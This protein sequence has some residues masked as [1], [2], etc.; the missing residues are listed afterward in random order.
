MWGSRLTIR[1]AR[2]PPTA[3]HRVSVS[4]TRSTT[5]LREERE[6]KK[7]SRWG[8]LYCTCCIAY[9]IYITNSRVMYHRTC[10]IKSECTTKTTQHYNIH[11]NTFLFRQLHGSHDITWRLTWWGRR[12]WRRRSRR[13][14]RP[15]VISGPAEPGRGTLSPHSSWGIRRDSS[16]WISLS[17]RP[18]HLPEMRLVPP[19][20]PTVVVAMLANRVGPA[21]RQNVTNDSL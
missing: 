11:T 1:R 9:R 6:R 12:G 4:I 8:E 5:I 3:T 10:G 17:P 14:W 2:F 21:Q 18:T 19:Y 13:E 7:D 20:L 15:P 16:S